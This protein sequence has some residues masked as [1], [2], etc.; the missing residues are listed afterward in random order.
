MKILSTR[1]GGGGGVISQRSNPQVWVGMGG[2][3]RFQMLCFLLLLPV[4]LNFCLILRKCLQLL[5]LVNWVAVLM[6]VMLMVLLFNPI[7]YLDLETSNACSIDSYLLFR[8]SRFDFLLRFFFFLFLCKFQ[9]EP[10]LFVHAYHLIWR[11]FKCF[12]R[13]YSFFL[14]CFVC[15]CSVL[16][17]FFF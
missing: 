11:K 5:I 3:R 2:K 13:L 14:S 4:Y 12:I 7:M 9:N 17:D 6:M 10:K 16:V 15:M 8:R 1:R